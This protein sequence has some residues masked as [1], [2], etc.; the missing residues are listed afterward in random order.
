MKYI[1]LILCIMFLMISKRC[2]N[3][4]RKIFIIMSATILLIFSNFRGSILGGIYKGNDYDSYQNWFFTIENV[5]ISLTNDVLF[6]LLMLCVYKLTGC[7]EV[8]V[9]ITSLISIYG[10]YKFAIDNSKNYT[11]LIYYFITFGMYELGLSAIRQFL[12]IS[13]FLMSFKFIH[14]KKF[15]KYLIGI[16]IAS[17]FHS[18]A[19]ILIFIYPFIN[20]KIKLNKKIIMLVILA[21][22]AM[23]LVKYGIFQ[24]ILIKYVPNYI[25][26]Y[27]NIGEELNSN[28]TV[29][30][31]A[32]FIFIISLIFS[33]IRKELWKFDNCKFLYLCLLMVFSYLATLHITFSRMLQ[34][35]MPA[36]ALILPEELELLKEKNDIIYK[37]GK[38]GSI[39]FFMLI[40][41]L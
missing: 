5:K 35:F 9:F 41:I 38:I 28:Y 18:S 37:I 4:G 14:E 8:F 21:L 26:K 16:I 3:K 39:V 7:F 11:L 40:Y 10:I 13:I 36:V 25:Y 20:L 19:A 17:M 24:N 6:N 27:A 2:N 30:L 23:I 32:T 22:L 33:N 1:V 29:F 31:I 34:Y 15:L 12:A